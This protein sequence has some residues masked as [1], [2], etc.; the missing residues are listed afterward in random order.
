[1]RRHFDAD[2][3][4]LRLLA[5]IIAAQLLVLVCI[6]LWPL[7]AAPQ[8]ADLI[9]SSP[10][11]IQMEE[12]VNTTQARRAP[13]PPPPLPPVIMADDIILE[14]DLTLDFDPLTITGPPM[15]DIPT[16]PEGVLSSGVLSSEPPKPIRIATPEYPRSAQRRKIHAEIV[17]ALVVD[18]RGRVQ[19]P[20]IIERYLLNQK[21][22]TRTLVNEL[23]YGLEE[24]AVN[25]ALRSL[26]RPAKKD[27]VTVDS[28]HQ[29]AFK[30]GT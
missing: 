2:H 13:P 25:A 27:G 10:D 8:P 19:S 17:I 15:E 3:Y 22:N 4:I 21:E 1:M 11:M 23:G 9:Y 12:I 16:E 18:K 28:N 20:R 6:K 7:P 26:F 14:E 24:A 30:F 29:L 5:G